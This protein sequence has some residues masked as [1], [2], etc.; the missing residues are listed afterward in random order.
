MTR[1]KLF[2]HAK[3]FGFIVK[4]VDFCNKVFLEPEACEIGKKKFCCDV[5]SLSL[6]LFLSVLER[7]DVP[8]C[9][10]RKPSGGST[11]GD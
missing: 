8:V 5:G 3:V 2:F 10:S 6:L 1:I 11:D 9:L 7:T 4:W